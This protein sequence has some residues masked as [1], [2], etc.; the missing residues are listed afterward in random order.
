MQSSFLILFIAIF[1]TALVSTALSPPAIGTP[2]K[3]WPDQF[4][5][6][7]AVTKEDS[8]LFGV[9]G[10]VYYSAKQQSQYTDYWVRCAFGGD[11][12]QPCSIV[13]DTKI[14]L[15]TGP[16]RSNCCVLFSDIGFM[17]PTWTTNM[18]YNGNTT[19]AFGQEVMEFTDGGPAPHVFYV[20]G[21]D[22]IPVFLQPEEWVW[23][24]TYL[25]L[26]IDTSIF[27]KP[28]SCDKNVPCPGFG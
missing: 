24:T 27:N 12:T 28:A 16:D 1:S 7:V 20:A 2:M 11:P 6:N 21:D 8:G 14:W 13:M 25:D 3:P 18:K 22:Q 5:A 23:K 17:P 19:F 9:P 26:P 15:L 4:V 10:T